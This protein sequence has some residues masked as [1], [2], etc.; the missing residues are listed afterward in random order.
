MID[1]NPAELFTW[2]ADRLN[3]FRLAYLHVI[4]DDFLQQQNGD[5]MTLIRTHYQDVLIGNMDYTTDAADNATTEGKVD[6]VAFGT[7]FLA[8][9]DL[10]ARIKVGAP[11]NS[12]N[13]TIFTPPDRKDI[14]IIRHWV[15]CDC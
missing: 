2:L 4:R 15:L 14:P 5:I 12:P 7:G 8:N 6:A 1:S 3:D 10:P 9:P 13:P 11:L